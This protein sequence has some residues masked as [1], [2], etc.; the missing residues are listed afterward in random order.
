MEKEVLFYHPV[1]LAVELPIFL[2]FGLKIRVS[3]SKKEEV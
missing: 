3:F 2:K 1:T